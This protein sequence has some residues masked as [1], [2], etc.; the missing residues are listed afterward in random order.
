MSEFTYAKLLRLIMQLEALLD[1][2][3][4]E[5]LVIKRTTKK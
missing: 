2:C 1:E 5:Y 4:I 3:N